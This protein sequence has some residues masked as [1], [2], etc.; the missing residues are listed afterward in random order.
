MPFFLCWALTTLRIGELIALHWS[1]VDWMRRKL[2]V[3]KTLW[4]GRLRHSTKTD[5]ELLKHI[6]EVL[7]E[8]L[9]ELRRRS[10]FK[11]DSDFI[12]CKADGGPCDP[13]WVRENVLYPAMDRAAIDRGKRTHG[14]HIFR[15]TGGSIVRTVTGDMKL[16]QLQLGHSRMSTTSGIY[17]HT[18]EQDIQRA[19]EA[20][21]ET[22]AK[23]LPTKLPTNRHVL[24]HQP[25]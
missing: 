19:G 7:F 16:A 22:I 5:V 25:N 21:A 23:V 9:T 18:N 20:L 13:D 12:F 3:T 4:R 8:A 2:T 11:A 6:P 24:A 15:H 14:F 1:D 10:P 17:V